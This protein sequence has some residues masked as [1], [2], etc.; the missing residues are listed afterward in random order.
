[1]KTL[2]TL[3]V[4]LCVPLMGAEKGKVSKVFRNDQHKV[5]FRYPPDWKSV[6]PQLKG[7][8]VL[9]Y[10]R[11]GSS[12]CNLSVRKADKRKVEEM[13]KVYWK[14]IMELAHPNSNYEIKQVKLINGIGGKQ[15]IVEHD[16]ILESPSGKH[17]ATSLIAATIRNGNRFI[18]RVGTHRTKVKQARQS[19][20]L[21]A[22]TLIFE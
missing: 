19:F 12:T 20:D 14:K 8:L 3:L 21:M 16:F 18:L 1:M 6:E 5:S 7:T 22:G 15:V 4:F 17:P 10:A 2:L 11:D 9:L 13:D